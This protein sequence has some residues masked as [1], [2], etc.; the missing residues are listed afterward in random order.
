[1]K[2]L[3]A[4]VRALNSLILAQSERLAALEEIVSS[5]VYAA[6]TQKQPSKLPSPLSPSPPSRGLQASHKKQKHAAASAAMPAQPTMLMSPHMRLL[7]TISLEAPLSAAALAPAAGDAAPRFIAAADA[8][9]QLHIFDSVGRA[10]M[11]PAS[12]A[13]STSSTVRILSVS[14]L[15]SAPPSSGK[16]AVATPLLLAVA[17]A[18]EDADAGDGFIYCLYRLAPA[19]QPTPEQ[20]VVVE[21]VRES[22]VTWPQPTTNPTDGAEGASG[23][24]QASAGRE[25]GRLVSLESM[26]SAGGGGRNS[27]GGTPAFIA[28]RS[29]GML[30]TLSNVGSVVAA[31]TSGVDGIIMARRSGH[32]MALLTRDRL[33]LVELARRAPPRECPI[34]ESLL[35]SGGRLLSVAFDAQV[36]QLVYVSS[37]SGGTLVFNSRARAQPLPADESSPA[38]PPRST[39]GTYECRWLDT[40]AVEP[41]SGDEA[42][43]LSLSAVRGY[44]FAL[45]ESGLSARNV[46]TIYHTAN[47]APAVIVHSEPL[48]LQQS[49]SG[50]ST[51]TQR[52]KRRRSGRAATRDACASGDGKVQQFLLSSG[53]LLLVEGTSPGTAGAGLRVYASTLPYTPRQPS[54]WPAYA[55]GAAVIG[56]TI[57]WQL[58]KRKSKSGEED[59]KRD[60]VGRGDKRGGRGGQQWKSGR[61]GDEDGVYSDQR[62]KG[63]QAHYAAHMQTFG[64]GGRGKG[65]GP[66]FMGGGLSDSD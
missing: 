39:A 12:L 10:L 26:G 22:N 20:R 37:S 6:S 45:S 33:V 51:S 65:I 46:S 24:V 36:S 21:L 9:G 35:A 60:K 17:L 25:D 50:C 15:N 7:A 8:I 41:G 40:L 52:G 5:G 43:A 58:Y 4:E 32:T 56:V 48:V 49:P 42:P 18:Q 44:L 53:S 3:H 30:V 27:K 19:R 59:D 38:P 2:S 55:M 34:P 64:R 29:D 62:Y 47:P 66:S 14:F 31:V 1:M 28:V 63:A 13:P 57:V 11:P 54:T 16:G 61:S 23:A